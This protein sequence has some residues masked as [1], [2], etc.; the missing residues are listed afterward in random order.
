MSAS[1]SRPRGSLGAKLNLIG[2]CVL[3]LALICIGL[4]LAISW[5]LNGGAAAVNE[6]GRMRM[7]TWRLAQSLNGQDHASLDGQLAQFENSLRLMKYGDPNRPLVLPKDAETLAALDAVQVEWK[8]MRRA[9][10]HPPALTP[11]QVA[12][13]ANAFV[14][15]LDLFVFSIESQLA[16][17]TTILTGLQIAMMGLALAAAGALLRTGYL[18]I[19]RPL[20][21]L[22]AGFSQV[23][24]GHLEVRLKVGSRDEFGSLSEDFNHMVSTLQGLYQNL[25]LQVEQKTKDLALQNNR[26]TALYRAA[27][28]VTKAED[29]ASLADGFAS[30]LRAVVQADAA[31]VRWSDQENRCY[32]LLASEGLPPSVLAHEQ[33]VQAS[34]HL[35]GRPHAEV[36]NQVLLLDPSLVSEEGQGTLRL[37]A[38]VREGFRVMV[39]VPIRL[40]E[41]VL[42]ECSLF[43][44]QDR[45]L[46]ADE[47]SLL[48]T[49]ASHLA[50]AMES[51][52][53]AAMERE[54]AVS[55]E[56][57]LLARELHDS[58]AQSL[59][60]LKI[61][62]SLLRQAQERQDLVAT[63]KVM[64]ELD[65]GLQESLADV[66]AL[67]LHFRTRTNAESI[68]P[69]IQTT[70][71]KFEHQTGVPTELSVYG[72][73]LPLAADEQVQ[74][75]HV[76]QEAL[77][78]VRKHARASKV[79]VTVQQQPH[80]QVEVRDDGCGFVE[81]G[82][83][84][85]ETHV[86]LRIMQER[87]ARIGGHVE[88]F[89]ES[90]RGCRVV[91]VLA[92][93]TNGPGKQ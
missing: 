30:Q 20:A 32:V 57:G 60:F 88:V 92:S 37:R 79:W 17:W 26:L 75:L 55:E 41:R 18:L 33:C 44:R 39:N 78:N 49:L 61:Q 54:T 14:G 45:T 10:A 81:Q 42:G 47:R 77:T 80:W 66:R 86:G 65:A 64:A 25:E 85:T 63:K 38:F 19:L 35:Y 43:F 16:R 4:T 7:L 34:A 8:Q 24:Q 28:W 11:A 73:G 53:A 21:Q 27:D 90:G 12:E 67:L 50:G 59:S 31:V 36:Q 71:R 29:L 51:L 15:H 93:R 48:D 13:Q 6:A 84:L 89:S 91:F 56:R 46:R 68:V 83:D 23:G 72:Q 52:R 2:A 74:L 40:H 69:A 9:W 58:I 70:L 82:S 3:L 62:V 5:R 87:A 76:V 1:F 22:Q